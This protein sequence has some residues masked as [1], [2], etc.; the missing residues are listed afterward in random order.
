MSNDITL[1]QAG[2]EYDESREHQFRRELETI[3][4]L[5]AG[6]L[7]QIANGTNPSNSLYLKRSGYRPPVGAVVF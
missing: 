7:E 6:S 3:L 5:I 4:L 1:T 2:A